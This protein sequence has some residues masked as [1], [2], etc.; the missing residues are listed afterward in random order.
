MYIFNDSQ[1]GILFS[2]DYYGNGCMFTKITNYKTICKWAYTVPYYI[3]CK[4]T[5]HA[6]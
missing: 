6:I 4:S 5:L 3:I 1:F 2:Y